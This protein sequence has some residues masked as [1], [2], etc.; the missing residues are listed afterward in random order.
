MENLPPD[1]AVAH[2]EVERALA[3]RRGLLERKIAGAYLSVGLP[4]VVLVAWLWGT[5]NAVN[6][7]VVLLGAMAIFVVHGLLISRMKGLR[8]L[9]HDPL[10]T[11]FAV[12]PGLQLLVFFTWFVLIMVPVLALGFLGRLSSGVVAGAIPAFFGISFVTQGWRMKDVAHSFLGVL[13]LAVSVGVALAN[14]GVFEAITFSVG[15]VGVAQTL[16]GALRFALAPRGN[17]H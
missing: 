3:Y 12:P 7:E 15:T 14:P 8:A 13:V 4:T 10:S 2:A 1:I 11:V 17:P 5:R 6:A 9:G 16:L